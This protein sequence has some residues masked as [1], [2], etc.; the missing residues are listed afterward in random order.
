MIVTMTDETPATIV[1]IVIIVITAIMREGTETET[2]IGT[3]TDNQDDREVRTVD[4][5]SLHVNVNVKN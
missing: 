4:V 2:M 1:I 3:P 5:T